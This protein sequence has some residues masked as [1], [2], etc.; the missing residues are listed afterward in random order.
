MITTTIKSLNQ[1][2]IPRFGP[3][4]ENDDDDGDDTNYI[5]YLFIRIRNIN[6][7]TFRRN[8][9]RVILFT[10]FFYLIFIFLFNIH[11]S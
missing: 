5:I 10:Q 9:T 1:L 7:I 4:P 8:L 2:I 3:R 11:L 6:N